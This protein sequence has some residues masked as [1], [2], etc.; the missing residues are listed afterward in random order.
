MNF[1]TLGGKK[2]KILDTMGRD[3]VIFFHGLALFGT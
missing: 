3:I 2:K 1:L